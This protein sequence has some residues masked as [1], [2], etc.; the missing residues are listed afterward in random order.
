[1][2]D[3]LYDEEFGLIHVRRVSGAKHARLRVSANGI[4]GVTLPKWAALG[5]A[6][7]LVDISRDAIRRSLA[8]QP[9]PKEWANGDLIGASHRLVLVPDESVVSCKTSI[10]GNQA[11]IHH[12]PEVNSGVLRTTVQ[13]FIK[14]ILKRQATA[15]LPRRLEALAREYDFAYQRV[16]FSSARTRWGSCSSNGTLSLNIGL[17]TLPLELID[18]VLIHELCH[19]RYMNHSKTFWAAVEVCSPDYKQHR[20]VLKQHSPGV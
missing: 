5:R 4:V 9:P 2:A 14:K 18:Y 7:Q 19:T 17:M 16:R 20:R 12:H 15:Y 6:R 1:M 11:F 3:T 10:R 13:T 8:A